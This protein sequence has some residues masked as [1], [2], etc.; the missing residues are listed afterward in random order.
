MKYLKNFI[1][2]LI[3]LFHKNLGYGAMRY[4][5]EKVLATGASEEIIHPSSLT[6]EVN[7]NN[8]ITILD[9]NDNEP[10]SCNILM[11]QN[12]TLHIQSENHLNL[13][14]L[15]TSIAKSGTFHGNIR[16]TLMVTGPRKTCSDLDC[17]TEIT[18][19]VLPN[20]Y[21]GNAHICGVTYKLSVI[22]ENNFLSLTLIDQD[23]PERFIKLQYR[24]DDSS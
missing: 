21:V 4:I 2:I 1:I 23:H 14:L 22:F 20:T 7:D 6:I 16:S 19:L 24:C 15:Y 5:K 11:P 3:L 10:F 18:A 17:Y 12:L 8:T 13:G 9:L